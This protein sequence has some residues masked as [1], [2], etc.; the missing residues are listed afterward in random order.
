MKITR[1]LIIRFNPRHNSVNSDFTEMYSRSKNYAN[2]PP[3]GIYVRIIGSGQL[4]GILIAT[5]ILHDVTRGR[6]RRDQL[7]RLSSNERNKWSNKVVTIYHL[8][9]VSKRNI[10]IKNTQLW[11]EIKHT[12][13][14]TIHTFI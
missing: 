13:S 5:G 2:N 14:P 4:S 9:D 6:L 10:N 1:S 8:R 7:I 11:S 12:I 3:I